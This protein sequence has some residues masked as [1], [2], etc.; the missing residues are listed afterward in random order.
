MEN[1]PHVI[2]TGATSGIGTV[3]AK[4]LA[5]AGNRVIII[6]RNLEKCKNTVSQIKAET[7]KDVEYLVADFSSLEST[8]NVAQE[9]LGKYDRL[10]VLVNNAG[11]L[12]S[13]REESNGIEM[14]IVVNHLAPYV[15]TQELLGLLQKTAEQSGKNSRIVNVSSD[16][17]YSGIN[18]DDLQFNKEY[19][20]MGATA[21]GQSKAMNVLFTLEQAR[22]LEGKNVTINAL[23]PGVVNTGIFLNLGGPVLRW[24]IGLTARLFLTTAE[25]GAK[26]TIHLAQAP[27]L[28]NVSGKY[29]SVMEEKRPL[30][31]LRDEAVWSKMWDLT[32]EWAAIA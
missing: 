17:H 26:T 24:I 15:L 1:Q 5:K 11:T 12:F 27:E 32:E 7:G 22:R 21:Y 13:K 6:G 14:H 23:H 3:T 2:V 4:E 29:Y 8:R 19:P 31:E 18:W 30:R 20:R 28:E 9:Y 16:A 25:E 10:D